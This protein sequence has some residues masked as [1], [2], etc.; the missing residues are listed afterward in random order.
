M[1]TPDQRSQICVFQVNLP[2]QLAYQQWSPLSL[3]GAIKQLHW[4]HDSSKGMKWHA[5]HTEK[6]SKQGR[7]RGQ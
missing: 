5:V 1:V 3:L 2:P 7:Y 6:P 4:A